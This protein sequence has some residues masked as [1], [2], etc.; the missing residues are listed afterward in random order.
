TRTRNRRTFIKECAAMT[1]LAATGQGG[2]AEDKKEEKA[3][4]CITCGTQ[5]PPSADPPKHCPICEDERQ[6]VGLNGQEWTKLEAFK[7]EHKNV[8]RQEEPGLYSINPQP[9]VGIG[10]RAFLVQSDRGN[11]LWD[12]VALLDDATIRRLKELGGVAGI[13]VSHPHYYTTMIE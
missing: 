4:I 11:I 12:C 5:Y 8:I 7:R 2:T 10:Q 9:K 13:A 6:Y 3:F 1:A